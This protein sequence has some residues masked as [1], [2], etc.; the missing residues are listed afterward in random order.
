MVSKHSQRQAA[1]MPSYYPPIRRRFTVASN[2]S[3][4]AETVPDRA[5]ASIQSCRNVLLRQ[6][7]LRQGNRLSRLTDAEPGL[8]HLSSS[9]SDQLKHAALT[10]AVPPATS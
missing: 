1:T 9:L 3:G 8:S 7:R 2:Q 6:P 5:W 4:A 10:D